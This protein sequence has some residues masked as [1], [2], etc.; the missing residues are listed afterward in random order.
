LDFL[1]WLVLY[2]ARSF[3]S[4]SNWFYKLGPNFYRVGGTRGAARRLAEKREKSRYSFTSLAGETKTST[5]IFKL[6]SL[7]SSFS[8]LF[9]CSLYIAEYTW[10]SYLTASSGLLRTFTQIEPNPSPSCIGSVDWSN[11][12][13]V[14]GIFSIYKNFLF[15]N[16]FFKLQFC[17]QFLALAI[18]LII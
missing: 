17:L 18:F 16:Q 9:S 1:I 13:W 6:F 7:L 2:L 8:S 14:L 5:Y 3:N 11:S 12:L 15:F 4:D 10:L